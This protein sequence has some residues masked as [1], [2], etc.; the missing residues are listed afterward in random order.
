MRVQTARV[1][2]LCQHNPQSPILSFFAGLTKLNGKEI[3]DVLVNLSQNVH[4]HYGIDKSG[5]LD[6]DPKQPDN[7][8]RLYTLLKCVYESKKPKLCHEIISRVGDTRASLGEVKKV[9]VSLSHYGI[10]YIPQG[11]NVIGYF[12]GVIA[13]TSRANFQLEFCLFAN[14]LKD[15]GIQILCEQMVQTYKQLQQP[16]PANTDIHLNLQTNFITHKGVFVLSQAAQQ[17]PTVTGLYLG[18][19]WS[20][21]VLTLFEE[22]FVMPVV[23]IERCLKY[24]IESLASRIS[25]KKVTI[26]LTGNALCNKH[27]WHLLLLLMFSNLFSLYLSGNCFGKL[28]VDFIAVALQH[29]MLKDLHLESCGI[30][31]DSLSLL[32]KRLEFNSTLELLDIRNN[33]LSQASLMEFFA[34]LINNLSL[35]RLSIDDLR[36]EYDKI[37]RRINTRRLHQGANFLGCKFGVSP[38][39]TCFFPPNVS[40][41]S[42]DSSKLSPRQLYPQSLYG[43]SQLPNV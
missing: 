33:L 9:Y 39:T 28:S 23:D 19:N 4:E 11:C 3:F 1:R 32:G 31:S 30:T 8:H 6:C 5:F 35:A 34:H 15:S 38:T 21:R 17:I 14:L 2:H 29:C 20:P 42:L 24:L 41:S 37:F 43:P 12:L 13:A 40:S 18:Y 26:N 25:S 27:I 7:H 22:K 16:N 36:D 10:S